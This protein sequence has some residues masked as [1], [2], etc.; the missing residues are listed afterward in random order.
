MLLLL[1]LLVCPAFATDDDSQRKPNIVYINADDLGYMDLG[2]YA[3]DHL[4][5]TFYETP[6]LDRLAASGIRFTNGYA[7]SSNCAPSRACV[8]TGQW[9]QRHGVYTVGTSE[10]GKA[11]DRKLMPIKNTKYLESKHSLLPEAL[12][13]IG[14]TTAHFGK[15]HITKDDPTN[16][17]FDFN[18][19][20]F[21]G[22]SPT[23][24]GYHSPYNYPN[25]VSEKKGEYL[26]DR[27]AKEAV[28]FI[29]KHKDLSLI[30][31]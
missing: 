3:K 6:N 26:T 9:P 16:H 10:R 22:G 13:K 11:K 7:A 8:M 2:C 4:E 23:K 21:K 28:G 27:L 15:W 24:G 19:G 14:Y 1:N 31:I 5:K 12:K 30:H 18:F 29:T 25:V 20:G 17:G